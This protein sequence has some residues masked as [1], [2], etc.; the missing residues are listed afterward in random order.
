MTRLDD[1]IPPEARSRWERDRKMRLEQLEEQR[2]IMRDANRMS[3]GEKILL[4]I[5]IPGCCVFIVWSC[6][7]PP[8]HTRTEAPVPESVTAQIESRCGK[9][10]SPDVKPWMD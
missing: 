10:E 7:N 2:A 4:S 1:P 3:L 8:E 5:F 6:L 9:I